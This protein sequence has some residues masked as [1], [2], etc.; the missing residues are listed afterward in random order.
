MITTAELWD[1]AK[2]LADEAVN[3]ELRRRLAIDALYYAVYLSVRSRVGTQR[4]R[5]P[6]GEHVSVIEQLQKL[7]P[8]ERR[9]GLRL[10]SL[11]HLRN[12]ARY[13]I[14]LSLT[15]EELSSARRH[16]ENIITLLPALIGPG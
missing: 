13:S 15:R 8:I 10:D 1:D 14:G 11:R 5:D 4:A 6:F 7:G 12:K 9:A 2:R 16:A 3:S